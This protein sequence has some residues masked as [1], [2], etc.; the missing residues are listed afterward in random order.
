M[1]FSRSYWELFLN[2]SSPPAGH[3]PPVFSP[4][5]T[6]DSSY[7]FCVYPLLRFYSRFHLLC[8]FPGLSC[9]SDVCWT[10]LPR[11]FFL[12]LLSRPLDPGSFLGEELGPILLP[13]LFPFRPRTPVPLSP[14]TSFL[15]RPRFPLT[16]DLTTLGATMQPV[17]SF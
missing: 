6:S 13:Y 16:D 9:I 7:G 12:F 5:S 4:H 8:F 1:G 3:P 2:F 11:V 10:S 17:S 15:M 14:V